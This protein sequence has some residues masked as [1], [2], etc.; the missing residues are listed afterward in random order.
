MAVDQTSVD[1]LSLDEFGQHL[2]PRLREARAALAALTAGPGADRPRLGDFH[3]A[4]VT[5]DR[6]DE[7]RT[8]YLQRLTA[9]IDAVTAAQS[10]TATISASYHTIEA[11]NESDTRAIGGSQAG[12]SFGPGA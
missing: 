12:A 7:M 1:L 4:R 2:D 3:D 8:Q 9:L 6:Y 10:A 11:R 5:A